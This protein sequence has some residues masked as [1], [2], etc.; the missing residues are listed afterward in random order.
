MMEL[1]YSSWFPIAGA[2]IMALLG[3]LHLTYTF[4]DFGKSP[5]FFS[6][7][8]SALLPQMR[9]TR[10][11]LAPGGRDYWSGILGFHLS[12]SLGVLLFSMLAIVTDQYQIEWLKPLIILIAFIYAGIAQK[13]WFRIP[14][15]GAL[16]TGLL[17]LIGWGPGLIERL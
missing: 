9:E 12:H 13:C 16:I 4:L 6:P 1:D 2:S 17:L 7:R 11:A 10:T 15:L 5:R 3:S 14:M 8:N